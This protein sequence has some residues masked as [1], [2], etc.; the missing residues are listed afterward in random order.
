MT[1]KYLEDYFSV[2]ESRKDN[3]EEYGRGPDGY[4]SKISTPY[5]IRLDMRGC[6]YRVYACC[7]S[8]AATYY[9][10]VKNVRY[11]FRDETMLRTVGMWPM[12]GRKA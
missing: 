10:L 8:N 12:I 6:W 11:C 7:F 5:S 9:V 1:I 4:G 2:I 3:Y